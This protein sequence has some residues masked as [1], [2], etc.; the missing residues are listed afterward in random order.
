MF[1]QSFT[2]TLLP[3][4]ADEV[5]ETV[6]SYRSYNPNR[7]DLDDVAYDEQRL[8]IEAH[9]NQSRASGEN[10]S[11]V[12]EELMSAFAKDLRKK[13]VNGLSNL[14]IRRVVVNSTIPKSYEQYVEF[15]VSEQ[16]RRKCRS[17]TH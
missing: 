13:Q 7:D 14:A 8:E 15:L 5:E 4:H 10:F 9:R 1:C 11:L 16:I 12:L 17:T 2:P 6:T 3:L